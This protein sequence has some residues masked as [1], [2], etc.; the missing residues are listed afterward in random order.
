MKT[1]RIFMRQHKLYYFKCMN[2]IIKV[3]IVPLDLATWVITSSITYLK[4]CRTQ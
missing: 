2:I 4:Y 1:K 3:G